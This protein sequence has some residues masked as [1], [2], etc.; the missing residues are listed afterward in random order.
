MFDIGR[1]QLASMT[2]YGFARCRLA[3]GSRAIQQVL[4]HVDNHTIFIVDP[5]EFRTVFLDTEA[6][7]DGVF[8]GLH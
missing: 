2:H 3:A 1:E 4:L 5:C 7:G 6:I 8:R